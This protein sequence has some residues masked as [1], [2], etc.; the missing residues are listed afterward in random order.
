MKESLGVKKY[1]IIFFVMVLLPG[2][3]ICF[4][5]VALAEDSQYTISVTVGENGSAD[6]SG[7]IL[8]NQG[9][10]QSIKLTPDSFYMIDELMV[11][12]EA[13]D[14]S[15]L[16]DNTYTFENISKNHTLEASFY[17]VSVVVD[18]VELDFD[19]VI[20][21]YG[22][23]EPKTFTLT[24][25]GKQGIAI[26]LPAPPVNF[27][28]NTTES[29]VSNMINNPIQVKRLRAGESAV[30]QISPF[31]NEE[32]G[33]YS[34]TAV[35]NILDGERVVAQKQVVFQFEVLPITISS[36]SNENGTI[37]PKGDVVVNQGIDQTFNITPNPGF[38]IGDVLVDGT[39][40]GPVSTYTFEGVKEPHRIEASFTPLPPALFTITGTA[41]NNGR[42]D[43]SGDTSI[44]Q[45]GEQVYTITPNDHWDIAD[46]FV[47]Q[48]SIGAVNIY[49]FSNVNEN[50]QISASFKEKAIDPVYSILVDSKIK[51]FGTAQEGYPKI[52]SGKIK[53]RNT[54]N[55]E[56]TLNQ[57]VGKN[58]DLGALSTVTIAGNEEAEFS[59]LPKNGLTPGTYEEVINIIG[60]NNIN[61][62]I[63]LNF[64]VTPKTTASISSEPGNKDFGIGKLGYQ[65]ITPE[66]ITIRNTGNEKN[67]IIQP[68]GT[69]YDITELSTKEP[70]ENNQTTTFMIK[71]K[72]GLGVGTYNEVLTIKGS[73]D[74]IATVSLSFKVEEDP[75][76]TLDITPQTLDF[77]TVVFGYKEQKSQTVTV[78]N[79]GNKDNEIA[80]PLGKTFNV[81]KITSTNKIPPRGTMAFTMTP[82]ADL[83][84]GNYSEIINIIGSNG[85]STS[86]TAT[87][88]V[89]KKP[90]GSISISPDTKDF[91]A[92]DKGY[93][94]ESQTFTIKNTG[95]Q[96]E[97]L[98]HPKAANY[99][100]GELSETV[101]E[102]GKTAS[103]TIEPKPNLPAGNYTEKIEIKGNDG[104]YTTETVSF[105]VNQEE[106]VNTVNT[107]PDKKVGQGNNRLKTIEILGFISIVLI[108]L[109]SV[110]AIYYKKRKQS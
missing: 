27:N 72:N 78:T 62:S 105:K 101:L 24:N 14:P 73:K 49:A 34:E 4:N 100:V 66:T 110:G 79:H 8:I 50:H 74:S 56:V 9:E 69:N 58:Y 108:I 90:V 102:P 36:S 32:V 57:P 38:Q 106:R 64:I 46:V 65:E 33:N 29:P 109:G 83:P 88:N 43:P 37:D 12:G 47:D 6:Q 85:S 3:G 52:E 40:V 35:F 60:T 41:E 17:Q 95:N 28:L 2:I 5:Q 25:T 107:T 87:F 7:E 96:K 98:T 93:S 15:T 39:S 84:I 42:I 59:V 30:Y 82:K 20:V 94:V 80:Q 99:L 63:T 92:F 77:G 51:D 68:K 44:T 53:I 86:V 18:P 81:S 23:I 31:E 10:S 54:G 67:T 48:K 16:V 21:G 55:Q 97:T 89:T 1:W 71:P 19:S 61:E 70:L 76:Y 75:I 91:G 26:G 11:D 22:S 104:I 103:F 45:G 13:I